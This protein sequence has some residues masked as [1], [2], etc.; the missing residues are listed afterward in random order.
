MIF[1]GLFKWYYYI[2][3]IQIVSIEFENKE[4]CTSEEVTKI[5]ITTDISPLSPITDIQLKQKIN[6]TTIY[7]FSSYEVNEI[8]ITCTDHPLL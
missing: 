2:S 6:D 1:Y 5:I 4:Q 7:T 3:S 8:T